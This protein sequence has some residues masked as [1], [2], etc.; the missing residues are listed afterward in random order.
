MTFT[1]IHLELL[2]RAAAGVVFP[3]IYNGMIAELSALNLVEGDQ[4]ATRLTIKGQDILKLLCQTADGNNGVTLAAQQPVPDP[5]DYALVIGTYVGYNGSEWHMIQFEK[6]GRQV[7]LHIARNESPRL[8]WAFKEK[9]RIRRGPDTQGFW[10]PDP[11]YPPATVTGPAGPM[12]N[13]PV[14]IEPKDLLNDADVLKTT[15]LTQIRDLLIEIRDHA[16]KR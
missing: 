12:L 13:H 14:P 3:S 16:H 7:E 1:R 6:D 10:E 4:G 8:P 9:Y 15:L 2:A 11:T 5:Y